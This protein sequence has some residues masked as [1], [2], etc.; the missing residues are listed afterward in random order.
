[1]RGR[2]RVVAKAAERRAGDNFIIAAR[3]YLKMG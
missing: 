3:R 2:W 1:M